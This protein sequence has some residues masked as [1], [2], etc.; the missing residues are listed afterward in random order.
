[1]MH[2][3]SMSRDSWNGGRDS[4]IAAITNQL[5]SRP[6]AATRH[7][8]IIT[9]I[10]LDA[11]FGARDHTYYHHIPRSSYTDSCKTLMFDCRKFTLLCGVKYNTR[12]VDGA[13]L[14]IDSCNSSA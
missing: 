12:M 9:A 4:P 13:F 5:P 11:Q 2:R 1:M 3:A 7:A 14:Q 8:A 10:E 6:Y